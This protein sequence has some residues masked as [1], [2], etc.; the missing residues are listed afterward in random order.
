MRAAAYQPQYLPRLHYLN[1]VLDA[2]VFVVLDAAQFTRRLKHHGPDGK[3]THPSYQSHAPIRLASGRHLLTVPVRHGGGFRPLT[4]TAVAEPAEWAR[5][6]LRSIHSGYANAPRYDA[7]RPD[8]ETLL[9]RAHPSLG[10]LNVSTV[11]WAV[12]VLL[13]LGLPVRDQTVEAVNAALAGQRRARLRRIVLASDMVTRRPEGRQ[14]G[15]A[16]IAALCQELGAS[17][18]LCGGTAAGNYLDKEFF[19]DRG[20]DVVIQSWHC[21]EYPQR[22]TDRHP[23]LPNLSIVDLVLNADP[24]L[25]R[26]VID[27]G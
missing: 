14:Q 25:A 13:Q 4:Q 5:A 17:E 21:P 18:Y 15:N 23:F 8:L 26:E 20:I 9:G 24:T 22:F 12:N 7:L 2:D 16:W 1:R 10:A 27:A 6:H 11:L 19:A 3:T